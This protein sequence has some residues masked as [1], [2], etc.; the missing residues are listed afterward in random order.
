MSLVNLA[1]T[2]CHLQNVAMARL[3]ITAVPYTRLHLQVA[4]GLYKQGFLSSVQR[5]SANGPDITPVEVTPD[6]VASR[7]LWLGLKYRQDKPVLTKLSLISKPNRRVWANA[8]ELHQFIKGRKFRHVEPVMPGEVIF[9][10]T[11]DNEVMELREAI[12]KMKGGEL[13]CRVY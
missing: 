3:P 2:C 4:L 1:S 12:Q 11:K 9:V 5:G 8:E 6:N 10:R 13:L 7:R